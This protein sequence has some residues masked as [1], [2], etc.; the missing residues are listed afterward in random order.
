MYLW[1]N[2]LTSLNH[3]VLVN[4]PYLIWKLNL[5]KGL[6]DFTQSLL[7]VAVGGGSVTVRFGLSIQEQIEIGVL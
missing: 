1:E 4:S 5:N 7:G 3:K 6:R 2:H